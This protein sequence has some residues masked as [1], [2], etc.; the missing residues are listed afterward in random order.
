MTAAGPPWPAS[1]LW[2]FSLAFYGRP[3]VEAA[4]LTLQ[5]G[6]GLDV[7]LVLLAA[8]AAHTGRRLT[9]SLAGRLRAIG[10]AYQA[11]VMQPLRQ[12]R[13]ALQPAAGDDPLAPLFADRRR[14]LLRLELDFERLEQLRLEALLEEALSDGASPGARLF[15]ANLERLYPDRVLPAPVLAV[16]ALKIVDSAVPAAP[17]RPSP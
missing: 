8:W 17:D 14:A 12:A 6:H 5:D 3:E 9:P 13:R 11:A 7:N 10:E 1:G 4:C 16:L 15:I 2:D